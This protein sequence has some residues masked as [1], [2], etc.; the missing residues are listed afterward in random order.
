MGGT[1][2]AE[3]TRYEEANIQPSIAFQPM[4]YIKIMNQDSIT[5]QGPKLIMNKR[6]NWYS[7]QEIIEEALG[8]A[9]SGKEKSLALF[10]FLR[11]NRVHMDPAE[12]GHND[13][14]HEPV[15]VLAVYG[16]GLCDDAAYSTKALANEAGVGAIEWGI[17]AHN[18]AEVMFSP[19]KSLTDPDVEVY[20]PDYNNSDLVGK[21]ELAEDRYLVSRVHHYGRNQPFLMSRS[22]HLA[23][24]YVNFADLVTRFTPHH[25]LYYN[26]LPGQQVTFTWD[27][28]A[29]EHRVFGVATSENMWK[30]VI[31]NA[32]W[33]HTLDAKH[34]GFKYQYSDIQNIK[35]DTSGV[36]PVFSP[37]DS[38]FAGEFIFRVSHPFPQLDHNLYFQLNLPGAGDSVRVDWSVD[39]V[40][41]E[42]ASVF[43]G[44]F[45]GTDSC[46]LYNQVGPL[47]NLALY[48][49]YIRVR[50]FQ[51]DSLIPA[52]IDSLHLQT[53]VQ[54][55]QNFLPALR[56]G[57][58][59]LKFTRQDTLSGSMRIDIGW[60]E[61]SVNRAPFISPVPV[62]PGIGITTDTA[63]IYFRWGV[64]QDLDG[65]PMRE[66]HFQLSDRPDMAY[67]LSPNFD[68]Y[69]S[70]NGPVFPG[71]KPEMPGFL[72]HGKTY[73]W[74]V[75]AMDNRGLWGNWSS[76]WSFTVKSVLPPVMA[77]FQLTDTALVITWQQNPAGKQPAGYELHGSNEMEGFTPT[78]E[79]LLGTTSSNQWPVMYS[80]GIPPAFYRIIA[81]DSSGE[82]S[83][84]T[85]TVLAPFPFVYTNSRPVIKPDT[86]FSVSLPGNSKYFSFF[87]YFFPDTIQYQ[88]W[89]SPV[90][91]PSFLQWDSVNYVFSGTTDTVNVRK[92]LYDYSMC[93]VQF[94]VIAPSS[95]P[96]FQTLVIQPSLQNRKPDV[97][98]ISQ[99]PA[100]GSF[101][102]D[103][104]HLQDGDAQYGDTHTWTPIHV[105]SWLSMQ[106]T[107]D[108][109]L[110][111][112]TPGYAA[113]ADSVLKIQ[114]TDSYGLSDTLVHYFSFGLNNTPPAILSTPDTMT[115]P[116]QL[117]YYDMALFDPDTVLGD[118][119][120]IQIMEGPF[121]LMEDQA[122]QRLIGY[123]AI[124]QVPDSLVRVRATDLAGAWVEQV[125][126]LHV[127]SPDEQDPVDTTGNQ[128]PNEQFSDWYPEA[129]VGLHIY[130]N[131][132]SD[133]TQVKLLLPEGGVSTLRVM[134]V[135][136]RSVYS[137]T[138][139]YRDSG[140]HT[141][142]IQLHHLPSGMYYLKLDYYPEAGTYYQFTKPL[143]LTR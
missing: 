11:R 92:M 14:T 32:V 122:N 98:T 132:A 93:Q 54:L 46:S 109:L 68:R 6:G 18:V 1:E 17:T 55:S 77:G 78:Q 45:N 105:P 8:N 134:D 81:L 111:Q 116:S 126:L 97:D 15:K 115:D 52:G 56:I 84:P 16:Y 59:D 100:L 141:L 34:P 108:S 38:E 24:M 104:I 113:I 26:L 85:K 25:N 33:D 125:F 138:D 20:Y 124:T 83:Q 60:Q 63:M 120:R 101:F 139:G 22:R 103:T 94:Q 71:F 64:G 2:D 140:I 74:R 114:V 87:N 13:E 90:S 128:N 48:T 75:R 142:G 53:R 19:N 123:P 69:I 67:V 110:L 7:R 129:G 135:S 79:T 137:I 30:H 3:N 70:P 102:Q 89:V 127:K 51:S 107:N 10:E 47:V 21:I 58:N 99:I 130:P 121:W 49:G 61:R 82:Q 37:V 133:F 36:S 91:A 119:V 39:S 27:R 80:T 117:Y 112:G 31:A 23:S 50:V 86:L 35:V 40:Q 118:S 66:Y 44:P 106:G 76:V 62:Y 73:Y 95:M 43:S 143:I 96:V 72:E 65:D 5:A 29:Y 131:P 4:R 136:G 28:Q 57:N 9:Q 41:W 12:H 88:S 42:N